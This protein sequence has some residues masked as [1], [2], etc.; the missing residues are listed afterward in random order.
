MAN[1]EES[2]RGNNPAL[3]FSGVYANDDSEEQIEFTLVNDAGT[4][5]VSVPL[6]RAYRRYVDELCKSL[7]TVVSECG[8]WLQVDRD[9]ALNYLA[10]K[11]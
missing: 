2:Q 5:A 9:Y 6:E 7:P 11:K 1:I 10:V 8:Q 4:K 3:F